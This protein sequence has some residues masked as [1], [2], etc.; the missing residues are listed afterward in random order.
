MTPDL[1]KLVESVRV[2]WELTFVDHDTPDNSR[3][4]CTVVKLLE[5]GWVFKPEL[6][7]TPMG[8]SMPTREISFT[9]DV[10]VTGLML[11][12]YRNRPSTGARVLARSYVFKSPKED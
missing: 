4:D 9:G 7:W 1:R 3:F 2:G 12:R 10:E 8:L 5:H 11:Q 6:P